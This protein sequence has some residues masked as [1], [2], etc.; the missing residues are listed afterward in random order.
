MQKLFKKSMK[1]H[2]FSSHVIPDLLFS[3]AS[4]QTEM[5][6]ENL[7]ENESTHINACFTINALIWLHTLRSYTIYY[8]STYHPTLTLNMQSKIVQPLLLF[9]HEPDTRQLRNPLIGQRRYFT[10]FI[11]LVQTPLSGCPYSQQRNSLL[12]VT[13]SLLLL[14]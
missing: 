4:L 2:Y 13:M 11:L 14:I 9:K 10:L 6:K 1:R 7:T 8:A 5:I 3:T 12:R